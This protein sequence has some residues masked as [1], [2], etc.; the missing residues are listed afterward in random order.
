MSFEEKGTWIY[1]VIALV[2]PVFYFANVLGQVGDTPVSEIAYVRP[3]VTA[4][5]VAIV[6]AIVAHI[7]VAIGAPNE[8]DKRD[9]RDRNIN[10]FGEYVGGIVLSVAAAGV[11]ILTM[12]EFEHFWIANALYAAF[13]LQALTTSVVK[14]VSYRRGL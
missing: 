10:R 12:A 2:V 11:L 4:I 8:A 13:I 14:I 1:L 6:V 5:V 7:V 3:M 9:E